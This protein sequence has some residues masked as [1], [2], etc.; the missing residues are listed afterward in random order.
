MQLIN[1]S[2]VSIIIVGCPECIPFFEAETQ[3]ARRLV[4]FQYKELSYDEYFVELCEVL[5]QYQYTKYRG[6]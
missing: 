4:G 3:L 2:G 5:F 6:K 1:N